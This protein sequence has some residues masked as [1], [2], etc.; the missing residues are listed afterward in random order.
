MLGQILIRSRYH[1]QMSVPGFECPIC[2]DIMRDPVMLGYTGNSYDRQYITQWVRKNNSNPACNQK[3]RNRDLIPNINLAQAIRNFQSGDGLICPITQQIMNEPVMVCETGLSYERISI[4]KWLRKYQTNP[5]NNVPLRSYPELIPNYSLKTVIAHFLAEGHAIAPIPNQEEAITSNELLAEFRLTL[6]STTSQQATEIFFTWFNDQRQLAEQ[7]DA[8]AQ[9]RM[10]RTF[11]EGIELTQS[12]SDAIYW[13]NLAANNATHPHAEAAFR[14][15]IIYDIGRGVTQD[16]KLA[17]HYFLIAA[18]QHNHTEAIVNLADCYANGIGIEVDLERMLH[19]YHIAACEPHNHIRAQFQLGLCYEEAR[20]LDTPDYQQALLWNQKA[21]EQGHTRAKS[22]LGWYYLKGQPGVP[23]NL[24]LAIHWLTQA[25]QEGHVTAQFNL[26]T[27]YYKGNGVSQDYTQA[28]YWFRIVAE[29]G[30][31][32]GQFCL[33]LCW[34]MGQG[35][36]KVDF[37][38]AKKWFQMASDQGH[39]KAAE[40]L[41]ALMI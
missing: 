38:G 20:G 25:A 21:A 6:D 18:E 15:A 10:G 13:Y 12:Y 8:L 31:A 22:N 30:Q 26:G 7:G 4:V 11:E 16:F 36:D 2:A 35:V 9:Y 39:V 32:D 29:K 37:E 27:C 5:I 1:R 24:R 3:I 17:F 19:W 41:A 33:G 34:Q 28:V 40:R 23:I 14:L